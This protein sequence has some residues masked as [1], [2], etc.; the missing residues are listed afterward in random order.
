MRMQRNTEETTRC[1]YV[2]VKKWNFADL[3]GGLVRSKG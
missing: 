2:V 3:T 1:K